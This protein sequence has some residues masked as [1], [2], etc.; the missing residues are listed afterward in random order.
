MCIAQCSADNLQKTLFQIYSRMAVR[1]CGGR[2]AHPLTSLLPHT[3]LLPPSPLSP[4][5]PLSP[6]HTSTSRA[7]VRKA[8]AVKGGWKGRIGQIN[9]EVSRAVDKVGGGGGGGWWRV[10]EG[11]RGGGWWWRSGGGSLEG[12]WRGGFILHRLNKNFWGTSSNYLK[13]VI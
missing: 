9:Q 12:W 13:S 5:S 10:V 6:L 4:H 1:M 2:L 8:G 3:S 7:L 11:L